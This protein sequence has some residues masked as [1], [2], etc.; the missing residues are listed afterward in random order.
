MI[1]GDIIGPSFQ[2]SK[3]NRDLNTRNMR[4]DFKYDIRTLLR[5]LE[6]A[7]ICVT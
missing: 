5:T 1:N 2:I 4:N 6:Y 7:D 3:I